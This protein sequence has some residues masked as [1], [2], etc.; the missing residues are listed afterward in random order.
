MSFIVTGLPIETF[1]PLF[2]LSDEALAERGVVRV[3][4][5]ADGRYPCRVSLEDAAPGD[6]LLLAN[7]ESHSAPTPYRSAYAIYVN[8]A[9]TET[10]QLEDE[11]PPVLR[12]RPIALR[13]FDAAGML[14]AA[15][16][17]LHDNVRQALERQLADPACAYIHAHNAAAG[18]YAARIERA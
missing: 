18:C 10:R 15:E 7:F 5:K 14:I 8:E 11:L 16:L 4:A 1:R 2:G 9:A 17:A 3:T 12:G 13:V 6:T